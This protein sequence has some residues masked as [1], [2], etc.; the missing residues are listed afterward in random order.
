MSTY[1]VQC[2]TKG[3]LGMKLP[4]Y[5]LQSVF[6]ITFSG[7]TS[8]VSK[9]CTL[10]YIALFPSMAQKKYYEDS[11]DVHWIHQR[12]LSTDFSHQLNLLTDFS[13]WLILLTD[14]GQAKIKGCF[15]Y[16]H[17]LKIQNKLASFPGLSGVGWAW[18]WGHFC[19]ALHPV[20]HDP[21]WSH[22][23]RRREML[24]V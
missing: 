16:T 18:E 1:F 19:T 5:P 23:C 8:S 24:D 12:L 2:V 11:I 13:H 15:Q 22:G 14:D 4:W 10:H 3:W 9:K 7:F 17:A 6:M 20:S 21:S